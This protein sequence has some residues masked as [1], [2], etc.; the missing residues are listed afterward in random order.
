ML[1]S[2]S[3]KGQ[4]VKVQSAAHNNKIHIFD[5]HIITIE[6][7][8]IHVYSLTLQKQEIHQLQWKGPSTKFNAARKRNV[9]IFHRPHPLQ[10][11]PTIRWK[12]S[13]TIIM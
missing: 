8:Y 12:H 5:N 4:I 10:R 1:N 9:I 6:A 13:I 11:K 3:E 7:M 2:Y